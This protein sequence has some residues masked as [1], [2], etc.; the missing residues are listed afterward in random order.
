MARNRCKTCGAQLR[1]GP[2]RCPL[3]GADSDAPKAEPKKEES[4]DDY[5]ER[6]RLLRKELQQLRDD[7]AEAV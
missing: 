6:V 7:D 5:Q 1:L 3:C 2:A 4:V